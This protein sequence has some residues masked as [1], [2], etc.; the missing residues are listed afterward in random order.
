MRTQRIPVADE[1]HLAVLRGLWDHDIHAQ[2]PDGL[3]DVLHDLTTD[4]FFG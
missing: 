4:G 1:R 2:H 3:A